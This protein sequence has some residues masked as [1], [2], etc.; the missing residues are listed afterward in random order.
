MG[1]TRAIVCRT[2]AGRKQVGW[3]SNFEC[4]LESHNASGAVEIARGPSTGSMHGA[5]R[6]GLMQAE[7]RERARS[8][9]RLAQV[10]N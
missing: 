3:G 8:D 6:R 4:R 2:L 9:V 5:W 7:Q 10:C 1:R